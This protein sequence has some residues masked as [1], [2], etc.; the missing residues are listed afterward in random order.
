MPGAGQRTEPYPSRSASSILSL[1]M[2]AQTS[3]IPGWRAKDESV[4]SQGDRHNAVLM[5]LRAMEIR[6]TC[7]DFSSA[8]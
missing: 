6:P 4:S 8:T 5:P 1:P 2:I 3:S 7:L